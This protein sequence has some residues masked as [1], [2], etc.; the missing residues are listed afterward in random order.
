MP[1]LIESLRDWNTDA[2]TQTFKTEISGLPAGT[3]PLVHGISQGG[4]VDE[5]NL[6]VT[7]LNTTE[8]E[9]TIHLKL[10]VFFSEIVG[11][12][13]CGDDPLTENAYCMIQ[14]TI[15]KPNAETEFSVIAE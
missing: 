10:G 3:L 8:D 9:S 13:S 12:C 1:K 6:T 2:F 15:N 4:L 5:S 7:I 11:G 14:V